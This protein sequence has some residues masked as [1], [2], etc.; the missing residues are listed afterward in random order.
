MVLQNWEALREEPLVVKQECAQDELQVK[1]EAAQKFK[2]ELV[3]ECSFDR[4]CEAGDACQGRA[5]HCQAGGA[6]CLQA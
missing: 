5:A 2:E 6:Q 3:Q 4:P 1:K